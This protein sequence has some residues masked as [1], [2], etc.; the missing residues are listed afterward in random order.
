MLSSKHSIIDATN[1]MDLHHCRTDVSNVAEMAT[2]LKN[3]FN[4]IAKL[5]LPIN[6]CL[7]A[8]QRSR[9]KEKSICLIP[10]YIHC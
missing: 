2:L 10:K 8:L 5:P 3:R 7:T 4:K 9:N 1:A 6:D